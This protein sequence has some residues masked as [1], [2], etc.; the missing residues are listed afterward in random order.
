MK[1]E[2][3]R[4]IEEIRNNAKCNKILIMSSNKYVLKKIDN[5]NLEGVRT[6]PTSLMN[7]DNLFDSDK[8]YILPDYTEEPS[9][10]LKHDYKIFDED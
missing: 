7:H 6:F 9:L 3:Q 1:E 4:T 8:I 2:L 10:Y 5:M